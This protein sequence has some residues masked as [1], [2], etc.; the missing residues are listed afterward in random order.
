MRTVNIEISKLLNE[1]EILLDITHIEER[2]I[3]TVVE[4]NLFPNGG[5]IRS[6]YQLEVW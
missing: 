3:L 4:T 5:G 2:Q 1:F 6:T